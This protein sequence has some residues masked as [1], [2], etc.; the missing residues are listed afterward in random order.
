MSSYY[1]HASSFFASQA[2]RCPGG[3]SLVSPTAHE[4]GREMGVASWFSSWFRDRHF[5][6]N[7]SQLIISLLQGRKNQA[8]RIFRLYSPLPLLLEYHPFHFAQWMPCLNWM[9]LASSEKNI[10]TGN[11]WKCKLRSTK[12][13]QPEGGGLRSGMK[14]PRNDQTAEDF[15]WH[16]DI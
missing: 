2:F 3:K 5:N 14:V 1:K 6:L 10:E 12:E 8:R 7:I 9:Q 15:D 4:A 16:V 11:N 13:G